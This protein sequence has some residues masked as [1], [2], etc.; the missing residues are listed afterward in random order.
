MSWTREARLRVVRLI[1]QSRLFTQ[2]MGGPLTG[3]PDPANFQSILDIACGPGDWVLD[4]AF[5]H[6]TSEVAGI[7]ISQIMIEYANARMRTQNVSNASFGVMNILK[8]LEFSDHTFDLV[9]ARFLLAS[10][11]GPPGL[12]YCRNVCAFCDLAVF[13]A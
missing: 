12:R 9:N 5:A 1:E 4:V 8:P 10:Y 7:D 11:P 3:L 13:C 2:C 6:P